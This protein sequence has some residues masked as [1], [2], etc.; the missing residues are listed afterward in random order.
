M[1]SFKITISP[2]MP[3]VILIMTSAPLAFHFSAPSGLP[4]AL[5][6]IFPPLNVSYIVP[7]LS[8]LMPMWL[9]RILRSCEEMNT[10]NTFYQSLLISVPQCFLPIK[11]VIVLKYGQGNFVVD[12]PIL[13]RKVPTPLPTSYSC[14]HL[15]TRLQ[16]DAIQFAR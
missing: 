15:S 14:P 12:I 7:Y 16:V 9:R 5:K 8:C 1:T 13:G 2:F 3:S 4:T 6:M 10:S 11:G